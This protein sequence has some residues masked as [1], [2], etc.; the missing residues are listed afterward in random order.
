MASVSFDPSVGMAQLTEGAARKG[1]G[2]LGSM[3]FMQLLVT[4]LRYQDPMNPMDDREFMA[5]LAQFSTLEQIVEQTRWSKMTYGLGLVGQS[6]TFSNADGTTGSGV[7]NALKLVDG[8]PV[9]AVG[10]Q[11]VAVDQVTS[12]TG[13]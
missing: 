5:Q 1:A 11:E 13:K 12:A 7:V 9:L 8:Q 10:E 3:D 2:G 6:V 4:Q